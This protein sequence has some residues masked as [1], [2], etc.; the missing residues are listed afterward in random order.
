VI[1]HVRHRTTYS[2]AEPVGFTRCA[3]RLTPETSSSQT[4]ERC[5][6]TVSPAA[7]RSNERTGPFGER[8]QV[9]VIEETH[10]RLIIEANSRVDV[11]AP[12]VAHASDSPAWE[13]VRARSFATDDLGAASPADFL[14]PTARTPLAPAITEYA[15]VSFTAA[16]PIMEAATELMG[17]IRA[18]FTYDPKA[19]DAYT[20]PGDAFAKRHGVCQDFANVMISGLRGVGL[21]A[22]YVTGYLRTIAPQGRPR[23]KGA[24]ATHAWVRLWCGEQ[25]GWIGFDPTNDM[26]VENDHISL[27][28]GRDA[29]DAAP[30]E[31]VLLTSGEQAL[32]EEVDVIP[33]DDVSLSP[34]LQ[35][36]PSVSPAA[37]PN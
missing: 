26:Y 25:R 33:Q 11:H 17:R 30:I 35:P 32:K 12:T 19:T 29:A 5:S 8:T 9:M 34:P 3:L 18:D 13:I 36:A 4:L 24:D 22:A 14:Y 27:M 21:P 16:R 2:Y 20:S 23:L 28:N 15:K 31:G 7:S 6:I 1:Y 10:S 37:E